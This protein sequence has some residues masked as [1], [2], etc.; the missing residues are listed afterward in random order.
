M[1]DLLAK[2]FGNPPCTATDVEEIELKTEFCLR[3][4]YKEFLLSH[5][6]GG[7]GFIGDGSYLILWKV[8]EI[9][10]FNLRHLSI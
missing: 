2:Y 10:E 7:E 3:D 1:S 5:F 6:D 9:L 4:D 8:A